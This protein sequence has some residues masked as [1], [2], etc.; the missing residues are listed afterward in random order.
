M[1]YKRQQASVFFV[2]CPFALPAFTTV[3]SLTAYNHV[4]RDH[5][6]RFKR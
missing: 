1:C 5:V 4:L 2:L 3:R 6:V